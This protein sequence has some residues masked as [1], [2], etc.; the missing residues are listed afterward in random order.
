MRESGELLKRC[1]SPDPTSIGCRC[2][3][4]G[5]S[6]AATFLGRRGFSVSGCYDPPHRLPFRKQK[7]A[8]C[9]LENGSD[10][11]SFSK[12]EILLG[13]KNMK[14]QIVSLLLVITMVLTAALGL[15]ACSNGA[16]GVTPQLRINKDTNY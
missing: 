4:R 11:Y 13:G 15:T 5:K 1:L 14:K 12:H 16:D 10:T 6:A 9:L 3:L 2:F 8:K 7:R